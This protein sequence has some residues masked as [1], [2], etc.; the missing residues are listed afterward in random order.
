MMNISFLRAPAITMRVWVAVFGLAMASSS[1][2]SANAAVTFNGTAAGNGAGQTN[3]ATVTFALS[4]SGTTTDLIVTLTNLGTYKPNDP[5]DILTGVFFTIPG[6][7]T[8]TK[9]S[10]VLA[11][12]SVGVENGNVL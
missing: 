1:M 3:A 9:I 10:G 8:L 7:P 2:T 5:P 4:I 6:D 12:G 11:A